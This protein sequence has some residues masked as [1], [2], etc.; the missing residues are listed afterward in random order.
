[1]VKSVSGYTHHS[2]IYQQKNNFKVSTIPIFTKNDTF[3]HSVSFKAQYEKSDAL[4]LINQ[5]QGNNLAPDGKGWQCAF[6]K[7]SD[8]IGI[9]IPSPYNANPN[10]DHNGLN[11]IKEFYV[12]NKLQS[13]NPELAPK[14]IDL[15]QQDNKNYLVM[16]TVKG[17]H[18][19][20]G[21]FTPEQIDN[22]MEKVF[23]MDIHGIVNNDLQNGNIFLQKDN[24]VKFIDF[25]SSNILLNDGSYLSTDAAPLNYFDKYGFFHQNTNSPTENKFLATFY[26]ETPLYDMKNNSEN[27]YLKIKSNISNFEHRSLY[28]YMTS[29]KEEDPIKFFTNYLKSKAKNYHAKMETYLEGLNVSK[30]TPEQYH[31]VKEAI[32]TEKLFQ[33]IFENP[34]ERILKT[35]LGKI[36]I[37]WLINSQDSY[38]K[39]PSAY[40]DFIKQTQKYLEASDFRHKEYFQNTINYLTDMINEV[41]HLKNGETKPLSDSENIL[42]KLFKSATETALEEVKNSEIIKLKPRN[43]K[44]FYI[45]GSITAAGTGVGSYMYNRKPVPKPPQIVIRA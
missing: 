26:S 39:A 43:K 22:L 34:D 14:P 21:N 4:R 30:E 45:L 35:E 2:G 31:A 7:M 28:D 9:K 37:K 44:I 27:P 33:E 40:K 1:M 42:K 8:D 41:P 11:N 10:P 38:M 32:D 36:Q 17:I 20:G 13:I 25:G 3:N 5:A 15:I 16:E 18:P 19:H 23:Q 24:T 12:L 6:F 29:E